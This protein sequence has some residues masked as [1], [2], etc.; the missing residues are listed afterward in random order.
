MAALRLSC[1]WWRSLR[2]RVLSFGMRVQGAV[3]AV[4]RLT[5]VPIRVL[6]AG[7]TMAGARMAV[8]R[9]SDS[10]IWCTAQSAWTIL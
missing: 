1:Y 3:T 7:T 2:S 8:L 9:V 6:N 5:D 10:S 4:R